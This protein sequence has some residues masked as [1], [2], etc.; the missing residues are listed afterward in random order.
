VSPLV[1]LLEQLE[2]RFMSE[3]GM[4][5]STPPSDYEGPL[6]NGRP[7]LTEADVHAWCTASH[8]PQISCARAAEICRSLNDALLFSWR[9]QDRAAEQRRTNPSTQRMHGVAK[10]LRTLLADLPQIIAHSKV[11]GADVTLTEALLDLAE[12][13]RP[14]AEQ[15][16]VTPGRP[17]SLEGNVATKIGKQIQEIWAAEHPNHR[18][19][20]A[21]VDA[22]VVYAMT[23]LGAPHEE[24]A[25]ARARRRR[26][27]YPPIYVRKQ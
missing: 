24:N 12:K 16:Q 25:L 15:Y 11:V 4:Y 27:Q 26:T 14:V 20:K 2:M 10:A 17:L 19:R 23:W 22:F 3:T 9:W 7:I 21:A 13:H 1:V 8:G 6:V 18:P 5:P